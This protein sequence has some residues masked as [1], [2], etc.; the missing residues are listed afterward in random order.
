M[1]TEE[2]LWHRSN[3]VSN[4]AGNLI[5]HLCGNI[6]QYAISALGGEEDTRKRDLE[7]STLGGFSKEELV[8]KFNLVLSK[9]RQTMLSRTEEEWLSEYKVQG[10]TLS[11]IGIAV[12]VVEHYAYHTG[13]LAF[14]IKQLKEQDLG[15][16]SGTDLNA[17]N[18]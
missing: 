9:A 15:F 10:F 16:Y 14:W 4:S 5:L 11:G 8:E 6:T 18:K 2:E 12:H 17:K 1:L 3:E 7:F 13:Q